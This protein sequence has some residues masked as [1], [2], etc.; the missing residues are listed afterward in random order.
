MGDPDG[1]ADAE[2]RWD[3]VSPGGLRRVYRML[4]HVAYC[5]DE[6]DPRERAVLD[7]YRVRFG[8]GH[9]EAGLLED[10]GRS[11]MSRLGRDPLEQ[12]LLLEA[13][14]EVAASDGRLEPREERRLLKVAGAVGLSQ[15]E[16][17]A[18]IRRSFRRL[19]GVPA[20]SPGRPAAALEDEPHHDEPTRAGTGRAPDSA[21]HRRPQPGS[22]GHR[23]PQPIPDT[24]PE[25][26]IHPPIPETNPE[27][28]VAREDGGWSP[29][30]AGGGGRPDVTVPP[31]A[32]GA[33]VPTFESHRHRRE[34]P[35]VTGRPRGAPPSSVPPVVRTPAPAARD[36]FAS[37]TAEPP[38]RADRPTSPFVGRDKTGDTSLSLSPGT[39]VLLGVPEG[40]LRVD[41]ATVPVRADFRGLEKVPPGLHII[42]CSTPD[43]P[44]PLWIDLKGGAILVKVW[45][46]RA[47]RFADPAPATEER[48][49]TMARGGGL[50]G[51][52]VAYAYDSAI[53][54]VEL[55][56]HVD[57]EK[58]PP[59]LRR[60]DPSRYGSRLEAAWK[61]SHRGDGQGLLTE[62]AWSFLAGTLEKN[63]SAL[64]R[65]L[66]LLK[67][68]FDAEEPLV[69]ED[70]ALF[71]LLVD[72]MVAQLGQ[73]PDTFFDV[74][75]NC[76]LDE[77][78]ETLDATDLPHLADAARRLETARRR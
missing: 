35:T 8:L 25:Q 63:P 60:N 5:D 77:L 32:L 53:D 68:C 76:G 51:G 3:L 42:A 65:W 73:M 58:F 13:M 19:R 46:M 30:W 24:N 26:R 70:P 9:T 75:I 4:C 17:V 69:L 41:L 6:L 40:N 2:A 45:D 38:T 47:R 14:V 64:E 66:H 31:L 7:A 72:L 15:A 28:P 36:P 71:V 74:S 16:L 49:R 1:T 52:L 29:G 20:T 56:V 78:A 59:G 57:T 23:R 44:A 55:T 33:H 11:G 61:G 43:G 48:W 39:V 37:G 22:A 18:L 67:A 54:W 12:R 34:E 27:V 21:A 10:E 50:A 62:V